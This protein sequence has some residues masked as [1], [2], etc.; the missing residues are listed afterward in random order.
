MDNSNGTEVP[1]EVQRGKYNPACCFLPVMT[2]LSIKRYKHEIGLDTS[3]LVTYTKIISLIED[4]ADIS[5]TCI[6]LKCG[7]LRGLIL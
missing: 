5:Y 7:R 6:L 1:K 3:I 4:T 2:T